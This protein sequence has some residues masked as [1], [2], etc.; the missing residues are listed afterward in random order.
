MRV[1][2][3]TTLFPSRGYPTHGLFVRARTAAVATLCDV[4]VVVPLPWAPP[5]LR[6]DRVRRLK[7]APASDTS[8]ALKVH[9]PRFFSLPGEWASRKPAWI[10][11]GAWPVVRS[12]AARA[13][14]DVVDAHFAHPDGAAAARLAAR[15]G[16]PFT[17]TLRGSDIHRDLARREMRPLLLDTL[18]RATAVIAVAKPLADAVLEAGVRAEKVHVIENGV[19]SSL[20]QPR[21]R[22]LARR[23]IGAPVEGALVL[24][25]GSLV[26]V[27]GFDLLLRAFAPLRD[28]ARL[29]IVGEGTGRSDLESLAVALGIH[30][31]VTFVG[32][33]P[34]ERLPAY[35]AAADTLCLS[36]RNEGCPNV[37]LESL[38]TGTPV[39]ATS[40]GHIPSLVREGAN[41]RLV[42]PE[43]VSA[44]T[45]GLVAQI[46]AP[47]SPQAVRFTVAD[48]SWESVARRVVDVLGAA[49]GA[50]SFE[51]PRRDSA[52]VR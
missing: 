4:E 1:L 30:D 43:D 28:H 5:L 8:G 41:G 23:E 49:S 42:T 52:C 16:I 29:W 24:A 31:R 44:L 27:K 12:L 26:P 48:L 32:A 51:A 10:A 14:F 18:D 46:Q 13:P 50:R 9:H 34:Q 45:R 3:F 17:I 25:V 11:H 40:V 7:M 33:V 36:S 38:A 19:D 2:T 22:K 21:D 35:Y 47:L 39:V 20:F 6:G 37:V 15:L